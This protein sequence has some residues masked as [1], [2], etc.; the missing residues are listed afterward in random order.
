MRGP[1]LT[2]F[3]FLCVAEQHG[4]LVYTAMPNARTPATDFYLTS[5]DATSANALSSWSARIQSLRLTLYWL[6]SRSLSLCMFWGIS[7]FACRL[8]TSGRR[9]FPMP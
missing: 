2:A 3:E 6:S 1:S 4:G 9:S 7:R 5:I 8:T